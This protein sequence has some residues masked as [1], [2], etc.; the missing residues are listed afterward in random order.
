[1][2]DDEILELAGKVVSANREKKRKIATAESCT[3]G[4]VAAAITEI[5]G[6]SDVFDCAF[7]TYSN[8]AK[9][10][11]LGVSEDVLATLGS[12]SE[13]TVWQMA[14][15]AIAHSDADIAV[16][17]SGIA[18]PGGGT[19]KKPVGTVAF[20]RALRAQGDEPVVADIHSFGQDLQRSEIRRQAVLVALRLLLP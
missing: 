2:F 9:N 7:I 13:G 16:A 15:G 8:G 19:D 4:L 3:G 17:I 18:G 14:Q 5:P 6:A 12:V 10:K 1:M 20:A 11:L